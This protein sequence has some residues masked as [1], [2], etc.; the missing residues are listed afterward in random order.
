MS[1]CKD[2]E[3]LIIRELNSGNR[4]KDTNCKTDAK[5]HKK[6]N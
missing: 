3:S 6:K 1:C 5:I 2:I 4:K